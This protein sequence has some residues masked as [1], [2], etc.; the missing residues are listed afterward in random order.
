MTG[1]ARH[2][3]EMAFRQLLIA[4][5]GGLA[6]IAVALLGVPVSAQGAPPAAVSAD[7]PSTP[8]G[9]DPVALRQLDQAWQ[10]LIARSDPANGLSLYIAQQNGTP[11]VH[12][13]FVLGDSDAQLRVLRSVTAFIDSAPTVS[14]LRLGGRRG[15]AP[16]FDNLPFPAVGRFE[17]RRL[18]PSQVSGRTHVQTGNAQQFGFLLSTILRL[19]SQARPP[20]A[21]QVEW[22]AHLGRLHAFLLDD[23]LRLYWLEAPAWHDT[24]PFPNMRARTLARL[25][26]HPRFGN[27]RFHRAFL[28][29]DL[30]LAAI[31]ADLTAT[32]RHAPGLAR[33]DADVALVEDV[34]ATGFAILRSRI[35]TGAGGRGFVFDRGWWDDN[36]IADYAGCTGREPPAAPCRRVGM[37]QNISHA[38]RWPLWLQSFHEAAPDAAARAEVQRWRTA[39]ADQVGSTVVRFDSQQRPLLTNYVDGH[40]GWFLYNPAPG[41]ESGHA[42][43]SLTGWSMRHGS[44][45]LLAPLNPQL[46]EANRRFCAVIASSAPGD[47]AFRTRRY[48]APGPDRRAGFESVADDFGRDSPYLWPCRI[49]RGL[50]LI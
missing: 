35:E 2:S 10:E 39:L 43:S 5:L 32:Y 34:T 42:P 27:M 6:L 12:G 33:S 26:G 48:G 38:Q 7:A 8:P 9:L 22:D 16:L 36:P 23:M 44:W 41:S 46:Q 20:R 11:L 47:V 24:G 31:A 21:D 30:H 15:Q 3:A 40:D 28:D 18:F 50:G 17:D 14:Q 4:T 45:A 25:Q 29:Y 37:T 49:Y 19:A 1:R 13:I